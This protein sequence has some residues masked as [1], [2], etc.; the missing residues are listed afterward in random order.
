[1][2]MDWHKKLL[3]R[4]LEHSPLVPE[5]LSVYGDVRD[6]SFKHGSNSQECLASYLFRSHLSET[7]DVEP[8]SF[9]AEKSIKVVRTPP[10]PNKSISKIHTSQTILNLINFIEKSNHIYNIK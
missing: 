2:K 5:Q 8:L 9:F 10:S 7:Y 3:K 6:K 1:M 4:S